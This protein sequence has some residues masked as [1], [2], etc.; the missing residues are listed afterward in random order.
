MEAACVGNHYISSL[1]CT[2]LPFLF[3][4]HVCAVYKLAAREGRS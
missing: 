2:L 4:E 1:I 3:P